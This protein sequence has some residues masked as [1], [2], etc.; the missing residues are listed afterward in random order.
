MEA[1]WWNHAELKVEAFRE[2]A[3]AKKR[4][5]FPCPEVKSHMFLKKHSNIKYL[6]V[7]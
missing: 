4:R 1:V 3:K 2:K 5:S 7:K 6:C